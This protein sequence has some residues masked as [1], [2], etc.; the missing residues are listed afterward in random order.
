LTGTG[1]CA[2]PART[3]Q[4]Q[5]L[6]RRGRPDDGSGSARHTVID[7][8]W[9]PMFWTSPDRARPLYAQMLERATVAVGN[10]AEVEVAVGTADPHEAARRLLDA[11]LEIVFVKQGRQGVLVATRDGMEMVRPHPVEVVCGLGAGDAFGAAL[12]HGL[13]AGWDPVTCARYANASGA[14]VVSRL[15]CA[16]AMPTIAELDEVVARI[17]EL[18]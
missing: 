2:E 15:A 11:G 5:M 18:A 9:R 14:L 12:V 13:I 17:E 8:D 10:L 6:Q 4:L 16:D 7:L 1:V 3:T